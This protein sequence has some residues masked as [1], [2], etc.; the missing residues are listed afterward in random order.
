MGWKDFVGK[1]RGWIDDEEITET[2]EKQR[3]T[4]RWEEFLISI[5]RG[6]EEVMESEM[7]TP[8]GG[9]TYIPREYVV[10]LSRDDDAEWQGEKREGL[11]RGLHT[12]IAERARELVGSG[13][14]QTRTLT[15]ELRVDPGLEKGKFRVQP[16]WDKKAEITQV[17]PRTLPTTPSTPPPP[18]L[19]PLPA[20]PTAP[21]ATAP[22]ASVMPATVDLHEA[23]TIVK[24]NAQAFMLPDDDATQVRPRAPL[25]SVAVFQNGVHNSTYALNK[26][27]ISIGRGAQEDIRLTGDMEI[28]RSHIKLERTEE[29]KFFATCLGRNSILVGK[30][31]IT[32]DNRAEVGTGEPIELCGFSLS[33]EAIAPTT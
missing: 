13:E 1:L 21:L 12:V 31:E 5:A 9:P 23:P 14:L 2:P 15:I 30:K 3:K 17:K 22:M 6:I 24:P 20:T 11:E 19:P 10:F 25:F 33:I 18:P 27:V 8:P 7:F 26:P 29:G 16:V 4:S 32:T 28:S